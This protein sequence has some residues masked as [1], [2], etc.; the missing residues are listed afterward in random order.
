MVLDLYLIIIK[1][2]NVYREQRCQ[3]LNKQQP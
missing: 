2:Q 3:E 1:N